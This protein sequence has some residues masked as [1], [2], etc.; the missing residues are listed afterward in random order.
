MINNTQ[1]GKQGEQLACEY[2]KKTGYKIIEQN[3]HF[4][5]NAEIDIIAK[6][7][8]TI[9]F[10]EVKARTSTNYGHPF[11]AINERKIKKIHTAVLG[12]LSNYKNKYK[13]FRIDGIAIIGLEN[14]TIEHI[15]NI[16]QY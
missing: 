16:G 3:W 13:S 10:I 14:P 6:E 9:V 5:K 8:D 11:E 15:K 7:K 12:Y 2:L 1:K 4:S